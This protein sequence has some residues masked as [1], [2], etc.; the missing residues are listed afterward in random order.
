MIQ[1]PGQ[2]CRLL[3]SSNLQELL[4]ILVEFPQ[5]YQELNDLNEFDK[6]MKMLNAKQTAHENEESCPLY[7]MPR[8]VFNKCISYLDKSYVLVAPVSKH[9]QEPYD[10]V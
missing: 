6:L 10:E 7:Q 8:K 3:C 5:E 2:N 9:F 4:S 1:L